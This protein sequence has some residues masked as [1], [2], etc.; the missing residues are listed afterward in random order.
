MLVATWGR[1]PS[2]VVLALAAVFLAGAVRA[3]VHHAEVVASH[4]GEPFG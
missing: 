3:A 2:A 4:V 1:H